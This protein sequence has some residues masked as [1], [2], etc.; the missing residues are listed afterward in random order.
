MIR[1]I[2]DP[3]FDSKKKD[4]KDQAMDTVSRVFEVVPESQI[5]G[6]VDNL[7]ME[8]CDIL[9]KFVYKE[10]ERLRNTTAMLKWHAQILAK[11]GIGS[12]MRAMTD[13]RTI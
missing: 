5:A 13:R 4:V 10:M 1:S 2:Q 12:I 9:M 8:S 7:D 3:P 11:A 6:I